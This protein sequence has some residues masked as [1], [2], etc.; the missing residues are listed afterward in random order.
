MNLVSTKGGWIGFLAYRAFDICRNSIVCP[1]EL[2]R[3]A[4]SIIDLLRCLIT[5]RLIGSVPV[6][7]LRALHRDRLF[8][9]VYSKCDVA[10]LDHLRI[11]FVAAAHRRLYWGASIGRCVWTGRFVLAHAGCSSTVI[12][13]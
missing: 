12:T 5:V 9:T 11:R 2:S 1:F 3:A 8:Y 7:L 6:I 4:P 10:S 13:R